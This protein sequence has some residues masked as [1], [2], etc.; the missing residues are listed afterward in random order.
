MSKDLKIGMIIGAV[1]LIAATLVISF[2]SGDSLELRLTNKHKNELGPNSLTYPVANGDENSGNAVT[3]PSSEKPPEIA[4]KI[5]VVQPGETINDIAEKYY[6][7]R[8]MIIR[9]ID[10]NPQIPDNYELKPGMKLEI[11]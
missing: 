10:A 1:L 7:N 5:H 3:P 6:G 2:L 11:P 9:I 8:K 4:E